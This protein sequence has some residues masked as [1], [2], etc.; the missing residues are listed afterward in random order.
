MVK[1]IRY[2]QRQHQSHHSSVQA[3]FTNSPDLAQVI[4]QLGVVMSNSVADAILHARGCDSATPASKPHSSELKANLPAKFNGT[5]CQK[6]ETYIAE[7]EIMFATAPRKH[8][9]EM[10]KILAAGLYLKGDPKKWFSNYFLLPEDQQPAWFSTWALFCNELCRYW[11]LED[12]EATAESKVQGLIMSDKDHV[13]YFALKFR[14]IQSRLPS[15]SDRNLRNAF[16]TAL[17]PC[18]HTQFISAG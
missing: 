4:Q 6:L 16:L 5:N 18:I 7:C 12:P 8:C 1:T 15:W 2:H 17:A 10:S 14:S 13:T 11:G 3:P 9:L